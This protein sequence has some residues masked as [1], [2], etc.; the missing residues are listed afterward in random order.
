[1][2]VRIVYRQSSGL[3]NYASFG[4]LMKGKPLERS[5]MYHLNPLS[6]QIFGIFSVQ[7]CHNLKKNITP[8]E[9]WNL[10]T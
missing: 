8:V 4:S 2:K 3:L 5:E 1:M 9:T 10:V 7:Y 6:F